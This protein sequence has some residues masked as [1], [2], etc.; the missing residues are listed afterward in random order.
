LGILNS[1]LFV[2]I[3]RLLA[4]EKGRVLPQVKPMI[5]SKLPIRKINFKDSKDKSLHD[6]LVNLVE[7]MLELK[8][9]LDESKVPQ[10]NEMFRR[11]IES[12]D[13]KIDQLVYRL[14]DL[15][16]EEIKIVESET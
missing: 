1:N 6:Q 4:I 8:Q 10:T 13:R 3:Y 15:T 11:Q 7:Q 12:T 9:R 14:Y 5:L 2:F 16:E